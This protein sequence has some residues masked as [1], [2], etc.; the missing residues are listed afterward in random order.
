L[1]GFTF[2]VNA[3]NLLDTSEPM[4]YDDTAIPESGIPQAS[5]RICQHLL[6]T[7]DVSWAGADPTRS[8][9]AANRK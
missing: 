2:C 7:Y 5:A 8:V 1:G 6:K 3:V 4:N 9:A